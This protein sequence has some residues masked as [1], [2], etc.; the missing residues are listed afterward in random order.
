MQR[1][2][3]TVLWILVVSYR[4]IYVSRCY[5][6]GLLG[7]LYFTIGAEMLIVCRSWHVKVYFMLIGKLL[8]EGS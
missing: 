2:V 8:Q 7:L 6:K 5:K 3:G 4:C 1:S